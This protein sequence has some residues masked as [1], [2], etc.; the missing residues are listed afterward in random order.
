MNALYRYGLVCYGARSV[1]S[2]DGPQRNLR[3]STRDVDTMVEKVK[4][5]LMD[6][7]RVVLVS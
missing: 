6:D 3:Y 7:K 1:D 2:E 5:A 4:E